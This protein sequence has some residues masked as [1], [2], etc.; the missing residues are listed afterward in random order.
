MQ[1]SQL[2]W[3]CRRGMRELDDLLTAYLDRHYEQA[4][5]T[6]KQAF[7]AL[8]EM[9]DPELLAY[10]VRGDTPPPEFALVIGHLL[11]RAEP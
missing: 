7:Q 2:R 11:D 6:E 9:A 1:R 3:Q 8:L 4:S 5:A 10:L